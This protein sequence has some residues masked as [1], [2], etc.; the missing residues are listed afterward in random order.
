MGAAKLPPG[1]SYTRS[2]TWTKASAHVNVK[3]EEGTLAVKDGMTAGTRAAICDDQP[4]RRGIHA[5]EFTLR[6]LDRSADVPIM[7][8]GVCVVTGGGFQV[9]GSAAETTGRVKVQKS[10]PGFDPRTSKK[11]ATSTNQGW[12]YSVATGT[13]RHMGAD[14]QWIGL[15]EA[16]ELDRVKMVLDCDR[17]SLTVFRNGVRLGEMVGEESG[18]SLRFPSGLD[19]A[20]MVELDK[21]GDSV[22]I[23][24]CAAP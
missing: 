20:W 10:P 24:G 6:S 5:A 1:F 16:Q 14:L 9:V 19:L 22:A 12:A 18:T 3:G 11:A 13:L 4:M 8:V 15:R 23:A 7:R 2:L 21:Y 17:G